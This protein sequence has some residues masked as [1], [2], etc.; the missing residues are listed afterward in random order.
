[1]KM[2][3]KRAYECPKSEVFDVRLENEVLGVS[4]DGGEKPV[5]DADEGDTEGWGWGNN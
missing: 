4:L 2:M 1:M 5:D 3:T